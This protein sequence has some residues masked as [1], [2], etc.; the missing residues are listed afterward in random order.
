MVRRLEELGSRSAIADDLRYWRQDLTS[1][2]IQRRRVSS[3]RRTARRSLRR[4]LR[5]DREA[6]A[7]VVVMSPQKHSAALPAVVYYL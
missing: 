6:T 4:T 3:R 7:S 2:R 5:Y 1:G